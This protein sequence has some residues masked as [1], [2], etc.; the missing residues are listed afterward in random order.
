[1]TMF[2][3]HFGC[4]LLTMLFCITSIFALSQPFQ[5]QTQLMET[6]TFES[7]DEI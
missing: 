2:S 1:M 5:S 4:K 6:C 3:I 7:V